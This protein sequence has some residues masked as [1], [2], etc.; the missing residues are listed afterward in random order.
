[1]VY[2]CISAVW[3]G[4]EVGSYRDWGLTGLPFIC[5]DTLFSAQKFLFS[6]CRA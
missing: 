3:I 2:P 1:M 5:I 4:Q 6:G